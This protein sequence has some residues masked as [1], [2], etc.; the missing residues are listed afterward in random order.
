MR[1]ILVPIDFSADSINALEH[2][3]KFAN[4]IDANVRMVHIMQNVNFEKPFYFRDLKDFEGKTA[5]DFMNL[6]MY[7]HQPKTVN[8]LDYTIVKGNVSREIIKIAKNDKVDFIMMGTH[9]TSGGDSYWVGSNAFK[10]VIN[11]PCPVVTIRNG[12]IRK[13]LTKI[14]L[15]IDASK[16]TR[17]KVTITAD[18][19][20]LYNAEIYVV[21]VTETSFSKII[22][23]VETWVKQTTDYLDQRGIRNK[24]EML[25]GSNITDMTI[26]YAK[27]IN[28]E[29]ISIMTEQGQHPISLLMGPYAQHMVNN[30][31]IPVLTIR[32]K[33]S[34]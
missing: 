23:K 20:E 27:S 24:A 2:G 14:V 33:I 11:A 15:P 7:R 19:A 25:K 30:S 16:H 10:V 31:P 4:K 13:Q 28:A 12:F 34:Y 3:I 8:T 26:D 29:L 22:K 5:Q 18:V 1:L 6:I 17:K 9:G 21:G 32:P